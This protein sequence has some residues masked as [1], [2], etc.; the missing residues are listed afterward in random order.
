MKLG[1]LHKQRNPTDWIGGGFSPLQTNT[2]QIDGNWSEYLPVVEFQNKGGFDRMACGN[3]ASLNALEIL[4]LRITGKEI[5]FSDRFSAKTSG[6]TKQGNYMIAAIDTARK[7]GL[8]TENDYPDVSTSWDDY[9]KDIP[10]ELHDKALTF[11]DDWELYREWV[12]LTKEFIREALREAPLVCFVKYASGNGL[13]NPEG[14]HDHFVTMF[15][16]TDDYYE[17]FD[18]YTQSRKKYSINYEFGAILKPYLIPKNNIPMKIK[19]NSLV[20]KT[21]G[22]G[23]N[24]GIFIDSKLLIG[25]TDDVLGVWNMRNKD[26][27]NKISLTLTDWDKLEHYNLKGEKLNK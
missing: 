25:S 16:M 1:A 23:Y 18:H 19:N 7:I 17:I 6:T 24:F 26:F 5:N 2:Y 27:N 9:Y 3:Y 10:Q 22:K 14:K 4:Y 21:Q 15:N 12:F 8:V 11:L 20:F 13:L